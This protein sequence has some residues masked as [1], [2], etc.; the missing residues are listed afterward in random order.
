MTLPNV[1]CKKYRFMQICFVERELQCTFEGDTCNFTQITHDAGYWYLTQPTYGIN[2]KPCTDHTTG[3]NEGKPF[4]VQTLHVSTLHS[5][6]SYWYYFHFR[7]Y[8]AV[9]IPILHINIKLKSVHTI[10]GH[11]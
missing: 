3:S 7:S 6:L 5:S 11:G 1:Y 10:Y 2:G 4:V 9:Q 8:N